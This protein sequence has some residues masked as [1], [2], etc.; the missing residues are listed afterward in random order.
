L[1]AVVILAIAG[2]LLWCCRE[3]SMGSLDDVVQQLSATHARLDAQALRKMLG[4]A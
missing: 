4:L 2:L 3:L 1:E